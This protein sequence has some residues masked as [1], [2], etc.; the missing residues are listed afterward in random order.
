V[1]LYT[2]DENWLSSEIFRIRFVNERKK[3]NRTNTI[4]LIRVRFEL[5]EKRG[6]YGIG[7][8]DSGKRREKK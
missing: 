1:L 2:M 4:R 5:E 3:F 7:E 6:N 8:H